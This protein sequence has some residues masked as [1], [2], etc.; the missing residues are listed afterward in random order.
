[1]QKREPTVFLSYVLSDSYV[2]RRVADGLSAAEI[3]VCRG[4]VNLKPGMNWMQQIERELSAAG[5]IA[6]FISPN[7]VKSR[8]AKQELQV[9]LHRQVSGEGGA[10]ILPVILEEADVPPLLRQF[11]WIDLQDGNIEKGI[12]EL[13]GAVRHWSARR[14]A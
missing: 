13:I 14:S 5:F 9:A 6:F 8:W 12:E 2:A 3:Q 10:V 7:F 4:E 11:Q 1:M